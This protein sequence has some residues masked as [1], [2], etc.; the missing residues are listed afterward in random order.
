MSQFLEVIE[1]LDDTG[2]E[3]VQRVPPEGS[4]ET[5]LGAQLIVRDSQAAVFFRDGKGLV[6]VGPGRHTHSTM[7]VPV[8]TKVLSL[9]WGFTSP[10]RAEVFFVSQ[11]L[12]TNLR[13]GT[14]DPVAFKDRELGLVRLRAF[15]AFTMRVTQPLLFV[16]MLVGTQGSYGTA[17]IEDY[18]RE[19]IV[20][21]VNDFLGERAGSLLDLPSR[22]AE[23][24]SAVRERLVQDFAKYGIEL[25]DFL[26]SR[27]TPPEEV[28][29]MIDERTGMAAV[30]DLD[31]FFKF[32]AGK[33]MGDAAGGGD[34]G[35]NGGNGGGAA[36]TGMGLGVGAGL[37]LMLPGMLFRTRDGGP[38]TPEGL[39]E[40]PLVSCG[41]CH[42]EVPLDSRF[43]PHCG[44][45]MVV[46]RKCSR[47]DKNVTAQARFC[48][49][50]GLDLATEL[51]CGKCD[52][53]LPPGTRFCFR[54]G[55]KI[56]E[57]PSPTP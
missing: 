54:C 36:G 13:W 1:W 4:G 5:K 45:Q 28:Q 37:G 20:S 38:V 8:L 56:S 51:H 53:R 52:A 43:C 11:K 47:C 24:A 25:V 10:F 50:C 31:Q 46:V 2:V 22:Y 30:G 21:R 17:E 57:P 48:S 32:R 26:V 7:N 40:R 35:G 29:R 23:M 39:R 49:S 12:F 19:L 33:A 55:E 27:I 14:K 41:D 15:G 6:G 18:L 9:P 44:H 34:G 16:N 42:G 3:I